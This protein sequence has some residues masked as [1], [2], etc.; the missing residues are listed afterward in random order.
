MQVNKVV[1]PLPMLVR[2][3]SFYSFYVKN[4]ELDAAKKDARYIFMLKEASSRRYLVLEQLT[5][6]SGTVIHALEI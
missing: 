6:T 2:R 4:M 5:L 3:A 1:I